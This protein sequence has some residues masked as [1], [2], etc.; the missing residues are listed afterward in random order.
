MTLLLSILVR[1]LRT[2]CVSAL[3]RYSGS[4]LLK[5]S[6]PP[7]AH[8]VFVLGLLAAG[9][10]SGPPLKLQLATPEQGQ[11]LI[12]DD[13]IGHFFR[14]VS[15]VDMALQMGLPPHEATERE[16]LLPRYQQYLAQELLAFEPEE[17]RLI[18]QLMEEALELVG[19]ALPGL[20]TD[21]IR[22]AKI[23]GEAYG[24]SV[25][26]TRGR[27]IFVPEQE[28][29]DDN[30]SLLPVLI[31]ELFHIYSR[32]HP[33][34]RDSLYR[35][36]GFEPVQKPVQLGRALASSLLLNP[37]G[38]ELSHAIRLEDGKAYLPLLQA[39]TA[40]WAPQRPYLSYLTFRLFPLL[41]MDGHLTVEELPL[42]PQASPGFNRQI[43]D[44]THY[45]IH[46]DEILADNFVILVLQQ[47]GR[48]NY[49]MEKYSDRGQAILREMKALLQSEHSGKTGPN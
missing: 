10:T 16:V 29:F 36:I 42:S 28:L 21:T 38:F 12:L 5:L 35:I 33:A 13:N 48:D 19:Q 14:Q 24:T 37:D 31:H 25:Y 43:G 45:I 40:G 2:T 47:S 1:L 7:S 6:A 18:Q 3:C 4:A 49:R 23:K 8:W 34:Q 26:F 27:T 20:F 32:Y 39:D 46:P 44:N 41:E 9:C 11:K 17:A 22:L 30:R 15:A